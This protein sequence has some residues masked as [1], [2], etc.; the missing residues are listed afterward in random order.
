MKKHLLRIRV[1]DRKLF[2]EIIKNGGKTIDT[3]AGTKKFQLIKAGDILKFVCGKESLERKVLK[4]YRFGT[5]EEMLKTLDLAKIMPF[6]K[7]MAETKK[8]WHS[9]PQYEEKIKKYGLLAFE[10]KKL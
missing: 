7:S 1:S 9:F 10:M 3:R 4:V 6:A 2:F 8:V 5:I